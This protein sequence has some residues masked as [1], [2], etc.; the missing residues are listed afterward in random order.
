MNGQQEEA[1]SALV[2]QLR[3]QGTPPKADR[4]H[5]AWRTAL[6]ALWLGVGLL[7]W[8]L[9]ALVVVWLIP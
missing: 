2:Q 7:Y 5:P 1:W 8:Y 9:I 6:L 3:E 4:L